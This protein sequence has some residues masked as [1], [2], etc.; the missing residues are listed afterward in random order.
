MC[1]VLLSSGKVRYLQNNF[2]NTLKVKMLSSDIIYMMFFG[3]TVQEIV[4]GNNIFL[5]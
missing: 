5:I 1:S 3:V 4:R 2:Q